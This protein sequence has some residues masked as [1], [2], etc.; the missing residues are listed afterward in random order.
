MFFKD[1][2]QV[3]EVLA[4]LTNE[5]ENPYHQIPESIRGDVINEQYAHMAEEHLHLDAKTKKSKDVVSKFQDK[6][7]EL[8]KDTSCDWNNIPRPIRQKAVESTYADLAKT[9]LESHKK[10]VRVA[11]P[12][13]KKKVQDSQEE[14]TP[15]EQ[16]HSS[17]QDED[18]VPDVSGNL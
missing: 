6:L 3:E 12:K 1:T 2:K 5:P 9:I 4:K 16:G 11:K 7:L 17:G 18:Q 15:D 8:E 13:T 14:H 10:K